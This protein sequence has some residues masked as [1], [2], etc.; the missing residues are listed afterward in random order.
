MAPSIKY[1][2]QGEPPIHMP[3]SIDKLG[4]YLTL[5]FFMESLPLPRSPQ[6]FPAKK[7]E[8]NKKRLRWVA[9]VIIG[10]KSTFHQRHK[11]QKSLLLF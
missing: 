4:V 9:D 6:L 8:I 10:E 7:K 5:L 1:S 2:Y 11:S 3:N